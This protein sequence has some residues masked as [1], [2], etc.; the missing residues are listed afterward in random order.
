MSLSC[1][2][3]VPFTDRVHYGILKLNNI[4]AMARNRNQI[5]KNK[6]HDMR[7]MV[8]Q[9]FTEKEKAIISLLTAIG[10]PRRHSLVLVF[11]AGAQEV[12]SRDIERG[13]DLRQPEVS[14][15]M[16]DLVKRGWILFRTDAM[17][18]KGRPVR[19]YRLAI[20]FERVLLAIEEEKK[21]E[22]EKILAKLREVRT[23]A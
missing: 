21:E 22:A 8:F 9:V 5:P 20:P 17:A 18:C 11:L 15:V 3:Y 19:I 16:K 2:A 6:V 1:K 4:R 7:E 13:T 10:I 12:S 14:L 23:F